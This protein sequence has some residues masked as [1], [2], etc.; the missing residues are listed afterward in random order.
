MSRTTELIW[1]KPSEKMP[2]IKKGEYMQSVKVLIKYCYKFSKVPIR[3]GIGYVIPKSGIWHI[4]GEA[5]IK[6]LR[7]AE[8]TYPGKRQKE[9]RKTKVKKSKSIAPLN[10][11]KK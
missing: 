7:W 10:T 4:P 8:I 9:G 11:H 2:E 6:V 5:H 1:F 3:F